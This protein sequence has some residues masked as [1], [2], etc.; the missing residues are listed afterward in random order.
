MGYSCIG[1]FLLKHESNGKPAHLQLSVLLVCV[2]TCV[3]FQ[4]V[5]VNAGRAFSKSLRQD[6][7]CKVD[8]HLEKNMFEV[9]TCLES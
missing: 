5:T 4:D 8:S 9:C 3:L 2:D 6:P 7:A 1:G